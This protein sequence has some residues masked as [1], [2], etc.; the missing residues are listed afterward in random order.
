M[1][2]EWLLLLLLSWLPLFWT[3]LSSSLLS[4]PALALF[5]SSSFSSSSS[6][7]SSSE[8]ALS[9]NEEGL[10]LG[11][12]KFWFWFVW[13]DRELGSE[14]QSKKNSFD[15]RSEKPEQQ[16]L[17]FWG[18]CWPVLLLLLLV[19]VVDVV[20]VVAGLKLPFSVLGRFRPRAAAPLEEFISWGICFLTIAIGAVLWSLLRLF[21]LAFQLPGQ[22]L[23]EL[24]EEVGVA[25]LAQ[26]VQHKPVPKLE[27]LVK[28]Q[29]RTWSLVLCY[30][31]SYLAFCKHI[32][33]ALPYV[34]V[35]FVTDLGE[36]F[37][38]NIIAD[39]PSCTA[40]WSVV[41]RRGWWSPGKRRRW[42]RQ[43]RGRRTRT[44]APSRSSRWWCSV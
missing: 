44:R 24:S 30:T 25:V 40:G 39:L 37:K 35:P 3:S 29:V 36:D 9:S 7:L 6:S 10:L 8:V 28:T 31:L 23:D 41:H 16:P 5:W 17:S 12:R 13:E 15:A 11:S 34:F 33:K 4:S 19:V 18:L 27:M 43:G 38:E 2:T 20:V 32:V 1:D 26:L 42:R 22:L 14:E 21:W